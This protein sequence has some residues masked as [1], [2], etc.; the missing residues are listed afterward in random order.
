[1]NVNKRTSLVRIGVAI[2]G[3]A[4]LSSALFAENNQTEKPGVNRRVIRIEARKFE[5]APD[6]II[7]R[8]GEQIRLALTAIDFTHGFLL[9]DFK[10][11]HDLVP[12]QVINLD[13]S[14]DQEGEFDFLCDNFCGSGH[15]SMSGKLIVIA[16]E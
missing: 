7:V 1:M 8:K 4:G 3:F 2:C 6:L 12:G 13:V 15:E 11:R 9:P 14:F 5:Y 16:A 10:L